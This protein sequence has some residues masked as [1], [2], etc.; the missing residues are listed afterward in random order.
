MCCTLRGPQTGW[1]ERGPQTTSADWGQGQEVGKQR[2]L[3]NGLQTPGRAMQGSLNC[4]LDL[5]HELQI[6]GSQLLVA[7]A[8]A[9]GMRTIPN[10]RPSLQK[11]VSESRPA[12][13]SN[14]GILL[15][16]AFRMFCS[17]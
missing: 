14:I 17:P 2:H 4:H 11:A 13:F 1:G 10:T 16:L 6:V 9:N 5:C 15:A 7:A 8:F 12:Q 3:W